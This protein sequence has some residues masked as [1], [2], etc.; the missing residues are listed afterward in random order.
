MT[1][2]WILIGLMILLALVLM[3]M[4]LV[5]WRPTPSRARATYDVAV[6]KDQLKEVERE[7][8]RGLLTPEQAETV[9]IELHRKLLAAAG[10]G[11][12]QTGTSLPGSPSPLLTA[13]GVLLFLGVGSLGLYGYLGTPTLDNL[14]YA[15]RNI[16]EEQ[17]AQG[18]PGAL[19]EMSKLVD[20]LEQRLAADP[21]N[22]EGWLMLGRSAVSLGQYPRAVRAY[23]QA[24]ARAPEDPQVLVDYAETVIF[25]NAGRV[26]NEAVQTLEKVRR[27]NAA[28]PKARYYMA[29]GQ[30]QSGYL[31]NAV[32][33]WVDL[34]A[35]SLPDAPW[36]ATVRAQIDAA[37]N[38][39]E[40][41]LKTIQP[42]AEAL[43]IGA[44]LRKLA[45]AQSTGPGPSA[46]DVEAAGQMTAEDRQQMIRSMVQRLA[47]RLQENPEDRPGWLKL[48]N[49]YKVLGETEKADHALAQ[50]AKL[51]N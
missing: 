20:R 15:E 46:E 39:A 29:L 38:E 35:I 30:A 23:E 22:L 33:E 7:H 49:A 14:A 32:Q 31:K 27:L 37:A 44:D 41:D 10:S 4:P 50:A 45:S 12:A 13:L 11:P 16:E 36:L 42:S 26:S 9:K 25:L 28:Q 34:L 21:E 3:V 2:V 24:V 6:Y 43:R 40:I 8:E 47:D 18:N 19:A 51:A 48:A 1:L 5:R 17:Q